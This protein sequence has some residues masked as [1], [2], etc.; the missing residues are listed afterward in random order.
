[1]IH[2]PRD[3]LMRTASAFEA[4]LETPAADEREACPTLTRGPS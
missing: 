4:G 3:R 1:M 2:G